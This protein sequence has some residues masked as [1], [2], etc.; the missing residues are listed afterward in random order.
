[1]QVMNLA[2]LHLSTI[3]SKYTLGYL[4]YLRGMQLYSVI[5][6]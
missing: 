5:S 3:L 1:M 2:I 6:T 4:S